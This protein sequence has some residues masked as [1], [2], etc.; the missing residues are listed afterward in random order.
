MNQRILAVDDEPHMLILLERIINSKTEY[1][2]TTTSNALEIPEILKDQSFDL[3]ITDY[4]MPKLNGL[5]ILKMIR[6]KERSEIVILITAFGSFET[7]REAEK[8]GVFD[9]ISKPFRKEEIIESIDRAMMWQRAIKNSE[10]L[11]ELFESSSTSEV[12][13]NFKK[14]YLKIL[15]NS[16]SND[17]IKLS[18]GIK[19][20]SESISEILDN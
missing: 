8:L 14:F 1:E 11:V 5:D 10:G 15:E 2:V 19:L 7:A 18:E 9:F 6:E 12:E 20:S 3:I 13:K 17:R 4:L 16:Y